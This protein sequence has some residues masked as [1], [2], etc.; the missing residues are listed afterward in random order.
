VLEGDARMG[1]RKRLRLLEVDPMV[2]EIDRHDL[3]KLLLLSGI[4]DEL[5]FVADAETR[6]LR[7]EAVPLQDALLDG[8]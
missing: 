6:F 3:A 5:Q 8:A 1:R 2:L 4:V 7:W